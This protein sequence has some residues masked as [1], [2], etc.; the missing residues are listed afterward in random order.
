MHGDLH[1][2]YDLLDYQ[3]TRVYVTGRTSNDL[4][5]NKPYSIIRN[6]EFNLQRMYSKIRLHI[7]AVQP[8]S[9]LFAALS[10]VSFKETPLP[11]N[12]LKLGS[13]RSISYI[14]QDSG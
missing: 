3:S 11:S 5:S 8:N 12:K 6:H 2:S 4:H 9:T 14:Q 1:M 13:V 7:R 10:F